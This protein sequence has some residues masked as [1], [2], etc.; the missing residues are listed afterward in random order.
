MSQVVIFLH[1][2]VIG[3]VVIA[4]VQSKSIIGDLKLHG[5]ISFLLKALGGLG[6][7]YFYWVIKGTGD[8]LWYHYEAVRIAEWGQQEIGPYL[9]YMAGFGQL[10]FESVFESSPRAEWVSKLAS[11]IYVLAPDRYWL[12]ATYF[13]LFAWMGTWKLTAE[14]VQVNPAW[15]HS[16]LFSLLYFP[17]VIFWASGLTKESIALGALSWMIALLLSMMRKP[18]RL[19]GYWK[20]LVIIFLF[21]ILWQVKYYYA[22]VFCFSLIAGL[23]VFAV[24]RSKQRMGWI[25]GILLA[26][27]VLWYG[28]AALNPNLVPSYLPEVIYDQYTAFVDKSVNGRYV[29]FTTL[30]PEWTCIA[31]T[32]PYAVSAGLFFPLPFNAWGIFPLLA[33]LENLILLA[34]TLSFLFHLFIKRTKGKWL[35]A[36]TAGW[37]YCLLLA[38]FLAMSA[39]NLGTLIRYRVGFLPFFILLITLNNGYFY[40]WINKILPTQTKS[41]TR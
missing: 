5:Y 33:G 14:L 34:V 2:C 37:I 35:A 6:I 7:G 40:H 31:R 22:A 27:P 20:L 23:F 39:P 41:K 29:E 30:C 17:S 38:G 32:F 24:R 9:S 1:L 36:H 15:K 25:I 4:F 3:G 13:S 8:T 28:L 11:L 10:P 16:V 12:A 19:G 18:V 21:Y 26:V